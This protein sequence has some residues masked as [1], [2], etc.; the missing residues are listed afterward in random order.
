VTSYVAKRGKTL[1]EIESTENQIKIT[2]RALLSQ[3]L[4]QIEKQ[5]KGHK[6]GS[7]K[8]VIF[9]KES[10]RSSLDSL[11]FPLSKKMLQMLFFIFIFILYFLLFSFIF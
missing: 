11:R 5:N 6:F 2:D 10:E 1:V 4:L 7:P 8:F 9:T 3:L